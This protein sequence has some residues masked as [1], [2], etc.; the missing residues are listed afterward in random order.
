VVCVSTP[1]IFNIGVD[2]EG[3]TRTGRLNVIQ[4]GL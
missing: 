1:Y 4:I 2:H 3:V